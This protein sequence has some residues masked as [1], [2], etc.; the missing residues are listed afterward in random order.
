MGRSAKP[1]KVPAAMPAPSR[2][3]WFFL[4]WDLVSADV[5]RGRSAMPLDG[6]PK[7]GAFVFSSLS[8]VL[9]LVF[10]GLTVSSLVVILFFVYVLP[11]LPRRLEEVGITC[12][13]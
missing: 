7:A 10:D 9:G 2:S 11:L 3:S 8:P 4:G 1:P 5:T 12:G 6:I 13:N